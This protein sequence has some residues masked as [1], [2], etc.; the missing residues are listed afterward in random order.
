MKSLLGNAQHEHVESLQM[1]K[2]ATAGD[3]YRLHTDWGIASKNSIDRETKT[4]K[5]GILE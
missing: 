5:W 4:G 1:V 3:R 2:Y